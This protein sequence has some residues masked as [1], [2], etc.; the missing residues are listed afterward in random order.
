[1][2]DRFTRVLEGHIAIAR[3]V[4]PE[5]TTGAQLDAFARQFLWTAGLDF[6]HAARPRRRQLPVG[7]EGPAR[8]PSSGTT[9]LKR[10]MILSNRPGT[11]RPALT[12]SA[13]RSC[14]GGRGAAGRRR[15]EAA[16]R[17][18]DADLGADRTA[19]DRAAT[20]DR[21][22]DRLARPLPPAS[23]RR[24]RRSSM[25]RPAP[26]SP[27]PPARS[28]AAE[29]GGHLLPDR[30]NDAVRNETR[31]RLAAAGVLIAM[32]GVELAVAQRPGAGDPRAA[33]KFQTDTAASSSPRLALSDGARAGAAGV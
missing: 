8:I 28:A 3:A 14:A 10:G 1:M 30:T 18:R 32:T 16:R 22:R 12:A 11:T 24:S 29:T 23:R 20:A 33:V 13:S 25:P 2:R 26:G 17:L 27:P 4:F 31:P 6:D 7:H 9:A 19:A 15:R 5:G 21:R